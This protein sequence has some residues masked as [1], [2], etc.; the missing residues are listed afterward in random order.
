MTHI[1]Y[2]MRTRPQPGR[3]GIPLRAHHLLCLLGF[4]GIGYTAGFIK[5]FHKVKRMVEQNP[6]LEIEVV[7]SCD[8]VCIQCPNAQGSHCYKGGLRENRS[9]RSMDRRVM[10]KLEI[11]PGDRFKARDLYAL[12]KEKIKPADLK[13]I[14]R[15]CEWMSL[16]FCIRGLEQLKPEDAKVPR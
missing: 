1:Q 9:V 13:D 15:G 7:D 4:Q 12:V 5:N 16:D 11:R 14:C 3:K 6:D 2:D 8:V 10:E